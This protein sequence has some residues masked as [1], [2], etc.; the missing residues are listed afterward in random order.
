MRSFVCLHPF[1]NNGAF[2]TPLSR[3]NKARRPSVLSST[4]LPGFTGRKFNTTTE[5]SAAR[6]RIA[7]PF[8]PGLFGI[9]RCQLTLPSKK[10]EGC[11][12]KTGQCRVSPDKSACLKLNPPVKTIQ[13]KCHLGFPTFCKVT[14]HNGQHRFALAAF[15]FPLSA[16]FRP[17]R[18][19][20]RPCLQVVFPTKRQQGISQPIGTANMP[21]IQKIPQQCGFFGFY[22]VLLIFLEFL[23]D[24]GKLEN[25]L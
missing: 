8:P 19:Q 22:G 18:Y 7:P 15:Q 6:H 1:A 5:S 13:A 4:P 3:R 20:R 9:T 25:C 14:R 17:R 2:G 21:G 24:L 10:D 23:F 16:S 11:L 12:L